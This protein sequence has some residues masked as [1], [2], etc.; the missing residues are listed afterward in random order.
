MW[1]NSSA[2]VRYTLY[3]ALF[4][5]VFPASAT[6]GDLLTQRLPLTLN[7]VLQVQKS[8]VLH[9]VIDTAPF[10]LGLFAS[11]IG[12]RQERLFDLNREL[13]RR[14]QER[15]QAIKELQDLQ[16]GLEQLVAS[17]TQELERRSAYLEAS[18]N[19]SH[20]ATS[21]LN[22]DRLMQQVVELIRERFNL[23]YVGLFTTDEYHE[24]AVLRAGTGEAGKA[25]LARG[26]RIRIGEGMI[27]W[28]IANA[29][30][31][32]ALRAELDGVRL[33]TAELPD[34]QSE[35]SLPLRSRDRVLGALTIQ[36][37][38]PNAFEED[39]IKVLQI[40]ADQVA[41]ALDNARLFA[42][43]Q[44]A[45]EAVHRYYDDVGQKSWIELSRARPNLGFRRDTRGFT[46]IDELNN[47]NQSVAEASAQQTDRPAGP[48]TAVPIQLRD[49]VLGLLDA[50]K[51]KDAGEWTPREVEMLESLAFQL[52]TA[53]EDARLFEE[54][55]RRAQREELVT[56]ITGRIRSA[57]GLDGIMRAAVQEIRRALGV[58]HGVI[59]V[60][61]ATHL[62][63]AE[64]RAGSHG[65][66]HKG[67]RPSEVPPEKPELSHGLPGEIRGVS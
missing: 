6:L 5:V 49:R 26:H 10:F 64:T 53:L 13:N 35:A 27:G 39:A 36:D 16:S 15:D 2:T 3:G 38:Y 20:V 48:R 59:R 61:T 58:S 56:E 40:M 21:I 12:K 24:W 54:A 33:A 32:I 29:E 63:S 17:R 60:G 18:A 50:R 8:S 30:A 44:E 47:T 34:T 43:S 52:G 11:F 7:S 45:L 67:D 37:I 46:S 9:W 31:R 23:Y 57:V 19:V 14:V 62:Q 66:A 25:M 4:G 55:Q 42:Q 65:A 22:P 28:T 51:P 41:I 1:R